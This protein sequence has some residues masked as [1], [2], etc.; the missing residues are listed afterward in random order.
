MNAC[1]FSSSTIESYDRYTFICIWSFFIN[2]KTHINLL[3]IKKGSDGIGMLTGGAMKVL[4]IVRRSCH[5]VPEFFLHGARKFSICVRKVPA[6]VRKLSEV[7][8]RCN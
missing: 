7:R 2:K 5:M 1:V 6:G 3:L 4:D 8:R